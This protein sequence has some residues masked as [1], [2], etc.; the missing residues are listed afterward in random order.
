V[1]Y[2]YHF[3]AVDTDGVPRLGYGDG[4]EVRVGETLT[5]EGEPVLCSAGL[6]ASKRAID[7]LQYAPGGSPSLCRVTLGGTILHDSDKAAATERTVVAMLDTA[8]TERLL[9]EFARWCALRVIH[10]WDAPEIVRQYLE[11]GDETIRAAAWAAARDAARAAAWDAASAAASAAAR[12]AAWAAAWAAARDAAW[13]AAWA[14]ARD[15][16]RAAAWDAASAAARAAAWDAASA[17]ARA[18]AWDAAWA[19]ARDAARD[20]QN[21]QLERMVLDAM[22]IQEVGSE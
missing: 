8:T 10:L 7:A 5:V 21:E 3:A 14:A 9:R 20:A 13:A 6:H 17:A 19:A 16:A 18:A 2:Y 22:Q 11:T 12:D 1:D 15:A 4:R